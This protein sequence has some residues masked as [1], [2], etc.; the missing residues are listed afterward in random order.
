MIRPLT[1]AGGVEFAG[2]TAV[3]EG[4]YGHPA[5]YLRVRDDLSPQEL[6]PPG[7]KGLPGK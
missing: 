4:R 3:D 2:D 6:L 1:G 7:A 5:C